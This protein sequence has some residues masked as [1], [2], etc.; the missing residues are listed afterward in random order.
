MLN[1]GRAEVEV[2]VGELEA[3]QVACV[4]G[5]RTRFYIVIGPVL[6]FNI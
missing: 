6:I 4:E 5:N 2:E 3:G 1:Q